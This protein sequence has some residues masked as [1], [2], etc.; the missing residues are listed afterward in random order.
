M[1]EVMDIN[2]QDTVTTTETRKLWQQQLS[3]LLICI[4]QM[5]TTNSFVLLP[6][7]NFTYFATCFNF[8][9]PSWWLTYRESLFY[10]TPIICHFLQLIC[11]MWGG[12][13]LD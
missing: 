6:A 8:R 4:C 11:C 12:R 5:H 13:G 9:V 2:G 7:Q 1:W 3:D 10:L